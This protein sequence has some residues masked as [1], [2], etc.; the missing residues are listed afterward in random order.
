MR[1]TFILLAV[2]LPWLIVLR[3]VVSA[4]P[5]APHGQ[6]AG[7]PL[8]FYADKMNL[9]VYLDAN[10][11]AMPV[12]TIAAW[13][14]RRDHILAGAQLVM[15]PLPADARKVP[16]DLKVEAEETL[17]RVVRKKFSFAVAQG[18]RVTAFLLIPRGLKGKLP[19]MV[20]L[21][22]TTK[23]GSGEPAG[24]GGRPNL[25]YALELAERG[26]V[27]LAPDYPNYGAYRADPYAKGYASATMK[28]I[29]N[30]MRAVDVL[31][32]LPEVD[33]ARIGC[34]GHSLGGHN[35]VFVAAFDPR[36]KVVVS[37]CGFN[38]FGQYRKGNLAD[39]SHKGYMPR[40]AANYVNS[41]A[42]M[43]FDFTEL[44][45]ALA[46][47]PVFVNAPLKDNDFEVEGVRD[48]V[49]AARPVYGL[50]DAP[51]NLEVAYPDAGHDF[52]P[53]IRLRAYAFID[54]HLGPRAD[55][56]RMIAHWAEYA[57]DDYL[58]FVE[59]AK[60]EVCQ[61]GFYG[62]HFYS[63]AHTPQYNGYPAHF[64]VKGLAECGKWFD[65]RNAEI[66]K[67]GPKVVG[68]F[69]VTFLVG[70]PDGK[71]GPRGFFKWYR[72]FWNDKELGAKPVADPLELMARNA[73]GTPMA[74]K[75]YSI[76]NMREFTACL[77]NP[78]WRAVLKAWAKAGI[79]RGVDGYMINYFYRHNCMCPHCQANFRA[80]LA[81]RFTPPQLRERFGIA[82]AKTHRFTEIVGWHDPKESTPLRR[83]M[84][85][86]SQI[87][88]K[89][90]FAEVFVQYARS[91][92][93]G[94]LLGQW[95]HLGDF[96]QI[97]GDE[98]CMLPGG[99]WGRDEDYLWYSTGGAA[100]F[101]D[102]SAGILGEGTLQ[103]RYI[104]GAF[105][106]KPF[107]L[108]KYESTRIR[109]AIA[110]LAANGGA[111]MGFYTNFKD[112]LARQEIVR[113]YRFLE[114]ND[115]LYRGNRAHAEVLLLYPRLKVHAGNVAA[116]DA[117]KQLGKKLL[118]QHVL[119]DVLPDD[120]LTAAVRSYRAVLDAT[121]SAELPTGLSQFKAP[122][123]VRVSASRPKQGNDVILHF[124]NYNREEPPMKRSAGR[125]IQDEKPIAVE[126]IAVDFTLPKDAVV[127]RVRISSP[128]SPEATVVPHT[129]KDGRIQFT[130]PRFLV[131]SIARLELTKK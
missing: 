59:D 28:G 19:A 63:L 67:R 24:L 51:D 122:T 130:L 20:C 114:K 66:H 60:P 10:G 121:K 15:G 72:E 106:N 13:Q 16:L 53:D 21:H 42:K 120:R 3:T 81:E 94:L 4:V 12:Q 11:Q 82:D 102:L 22:Q 91:L 61:I 23:I 38:A 70:E 18:D 99:L 37:S 54:R 123:T 108:G 127:S 9:L 31:Q 45:G 43:P 109:A 6:A 92:K 124:V 47:R 49:T 40:I 116:V 74:S 100:C 52:P 95:N 77:N 71:E 128:E 113:Y 58:K 84:L 25:H 41:A 2:L 89:Q 56:T 126:G 68:H 105:D 55:F 17:A 103:A 65:K 62:G 80:Y 32:A 69:N 112:G 115:A 48:C 26:Y 7:A 46:P 110:E 79:A 57:G 85:R 5:Q 90:A 86:W 14:K 107:T 27:T 117:F 111:P 83:E 98:R 30:H 34:I 76:G 35:A 131:Y 29:W 129:T 33:G 78:H 101:T 104:R 39:W 36:I 8:P 88:C 118:D 44:L 75:T 125:G 1:K 64:P 97:N 73:D 119:F 50:Y 87:S 96:N 93:P